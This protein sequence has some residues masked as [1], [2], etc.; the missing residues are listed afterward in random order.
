M[1]SP[2]P[3]TIKGWQRQF[4]TANDR[5]I[6]VANES[7]GL[8]ARKRHEAV[9]LGAWPLVADARLKTVLGLRTQCKS[10]A[11][12]E[13]NSS[14]DNSRQHHG[15]VLDFAVLALHE[16]IRTYASKEPFVLV[17]VVG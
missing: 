2:S 8:C 7:R 10:D 14:A 11:S 5:V 13:F 9:A 16:D 17:R 15:N 12:T 3:C 4:L 1:T 6:A